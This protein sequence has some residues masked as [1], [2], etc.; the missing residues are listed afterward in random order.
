MCRHAKEKLFL[1][2]DRCNSSKCSFAR[3]PYVPGIAGPKSKFR[4]QTDFGKQLLEK[5]KVRY[6]YDLRESQLRSYFDKARKTKKATGVVFLQLLER[7][8]DNVIYRLG[9]APSRRAA[10]QMINH[11]FVKIDDKKTAIPSRLVKK[12]DQIKVNFREEKKA[13]KTEIPKWLKFDKKKNEAA[14]VELPERSDINE[15][16]DEQLIVEYYSR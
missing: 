2:G 13:Q 6:L 16:I 7:R 1:K 5:Q 9:L 4:R 3:R 15:K 12:D 14:V 10:S 8:L 11:G